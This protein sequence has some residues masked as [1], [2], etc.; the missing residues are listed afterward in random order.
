[1]FVM[2]SSSVP[3]DIIP[4]C[5]LIMHQKTRYFYEENKVNITIPYFPDSSSKYFLYNLLVCDIICW[6]VILFTCIIE[7]LTI[8]PSSEIND[9]V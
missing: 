4:E 9:Y 6:Y 5:H 8:T 1:M 2:A 3:V 7:K